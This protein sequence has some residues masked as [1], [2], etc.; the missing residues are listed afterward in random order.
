MFGLCTI[1]S[2]LF[3]SI[4][5]I[6]ENLRNISDTFT[7]LEGNL[8]ISLL[9]YQSDMTGDV[10][11]VEGSMS[12]RDFSK[13]FTAP[14]R[15]YLQGGYNWRNGTLLLLANPTSEILVSDY[16]ISFDELM[17]IS[18]ESLRGMIAQRSDPREE[19]HELVSSPFYW[20]SL[21][22]ESS[23]SFFDFVDYYRYTAF[24]RSLEEERRRDGSHAESDEKVLIG[25]E[26]GVPNPND[27][28][29]PGGVNQSHLSPTMRNNPITASG[30]DLAER[31]C[32]FKV[33][34]LF[35]PLVDQTVRE[36]DYGDYNSEKK[37]HRALVLLESPN[38]RVQVAANLTSYLSERQY[39]KMSNYNLFF[40]LTCLVQ[41]VVIIEI[42]NYPTQTI[43]FAK[44][45]SHFMLTQSL[46][47]SYLCLIHLTYG[48]FFEKLWRQFF[49]TSFFYFVL[50]AAYELYLSYLVWR[51]SNPLAAANDSPQTH[52]KNL[53]LLFY[54]LILF[55]FLVQYW[56]FT[57]GLYYVIL[58]IIYS[59]WCFQIFHNALHDVTQSMR[60]AHLFGLSFPKLLF[61]LYFL[62]CPSNYFRS[63]PVP[64]FSAILTFWVAFQLAVLYLQERWGSRFFI[65][66]RF[67][68]SN[69]NYL[70]TKSWDQD[71]EC[72]ICR[73]DISQEERYMVTPC[74][75]IFHQACL[76]QWFQHKLEC[77]TCRG[78]VP[79][80]RST[81]M[82]GKTD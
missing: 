72:L 31:P 6:D 10:D 4:L 13:P 1:L 51:V 21:A 63:A 5:C 7:N 66:A 27:T 45:S 79:V 43:S 14:Q 16:R 12:I 38:C 33:L 26:L 47:D 59:F 76:L 23:R 35:E 74:Q 60:F 48:I 25:S 64:L 69:H 17:S 55:G 75:H 68:P 44:I 58:F 41:L 34:M 39:R 8:T 57:Y 53:Y 11:L 37:F 19:Q 22:R 36:E 78:H 46:I 54:G 50:F 71:P 52:F 3:L 82:E 70:Q 81:E 49:F 42:F 40:S 67:L 32:F 65:P 56:S 9:N 62:A 80:P 20:A 30:A 73:C 61:P 2:T 24:N 29:Q 18:A 28:N 15:F 77:P